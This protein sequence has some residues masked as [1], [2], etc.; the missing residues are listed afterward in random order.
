MVPDGKRNLVPT[1]R[2]RQPMVEQNIQMALAVSDYA[3]VLSNGRI[4]I[5]G[6]AKEVRAMETVRQ[7]YLGL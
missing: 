2:N 6:Q 7:A 1:G 4:T 5:E 3:Y